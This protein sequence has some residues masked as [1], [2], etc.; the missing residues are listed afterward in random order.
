MFAFHAQVVSL[1]VA[2]T[3]T[4]RLMERRLAQVASL[5]P[6]KFGAGMSYSILDLKQ[7]RLAFRLA[8]LL[9]YGGIG[10][11]LVGLVV[12][13]LYDSHQH[14]AATLWLVNVTL[15]YAALLWIWGAVWRETL[16]RRAPIDADTSLGRL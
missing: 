15:L 13:C 12:L 14:G 1:S 16:R 7:G 3:A 8:T 11:V 4:C 5:E 9:M 2:K 10:A 6:D